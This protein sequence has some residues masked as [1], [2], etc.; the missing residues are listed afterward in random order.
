MLLN[1]NDS[2]NEKYLFHHNKPIALYSIKITITFYKLLICLETMI[3][4]KLHLIKILLLLSYGQH[5][6]VIW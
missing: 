4:K 5:A 1:D 3:Q 2:D 6:G